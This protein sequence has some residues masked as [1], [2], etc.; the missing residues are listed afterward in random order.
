MQNWQKQNCPTDC[1]QADIDGNGMV[2]L[3]DLSI[4]AAHWLRNSIIQLFT[5]A[6]SHRRDGVTLPL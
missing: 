6:K 1:E 3:E 5:V 2:G 4:L